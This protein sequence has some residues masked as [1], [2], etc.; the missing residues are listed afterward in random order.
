MWEVHEFAVYVVRIW[1]DTKDRV[2]IG[3]LVRGGGVELMIIQQITT[4]QVN[5][6]LTLAYY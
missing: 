6:E 2:K 1:F 4:S 3:D 5:I